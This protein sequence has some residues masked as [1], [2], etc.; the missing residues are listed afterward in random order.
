MVSKN[1]IN[2]LLFFVYIFPILSFQRIYNCFGIKESK[3]LLLRNKYSNYIKMSKKEHQKFQW[4]LFKK[5]FNGN[6]ISPY[7]YIY[8]TDKKLINI[9]YNTQYNITFYENNTCLWKG[10]GLRFTEG[11]KELYYNETNLNENGMVFLFSN[12][13]GHSYKNFNNNNI[14]KLIPIEV[15]FFDKEIR[16]MIIIY[17]KVNENKNIELDCI[18]ITPFRNNSHYKYIPFIKKTDDI[19]NHMSDNNWYGERYYYGYNDKSYNKQILQEFNIFPYL[20]TDNN[21]MKATFEDGL[22]L[23]VPKIIPIGQHFKLLFGALMN[24]NLYKQLVINYD[25]HGNLTKWV[26]DVY[27]KNI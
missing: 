2:I 22:I 24:N 27:I 26:Y 20:S 16:S 3:S 8:D 9:L 11:I 19:I 21:L 13:G 4:N 18:Q 17:Y 7:T 25:I 15:N 5:S 10:S 1:I 6:W 12:C 23:I 14:N